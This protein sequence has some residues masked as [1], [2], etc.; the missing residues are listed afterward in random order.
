LIDQIYRFENLNDFT[1][2]ED[3]EEALSGHLEVFEKQKKL[4]K[5]RG[6]AHK[7]SPYS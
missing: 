6:K 3:L 5:K 4:K 2:Q 1:K 7:V